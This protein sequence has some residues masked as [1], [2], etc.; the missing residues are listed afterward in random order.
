MSECFFSTRISILDNAGNSIWL[1]VKREVKSIN[2]SLIL[3]NAVTICDTK[4]S[5]SAILM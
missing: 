3:G 4:L 5:A 1:S 2:T